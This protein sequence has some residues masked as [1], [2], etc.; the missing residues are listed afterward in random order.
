MR[1]ALIKENSRKEKSNK[2]TN[3]TPIH[4][5]SIAKKTHKSKSRH[6]FQFSPID[7]AQQENILPTQITNKP[8]K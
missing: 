2:K 7:G 5:P 3:T 4:N 6:Q 1:I 8:R